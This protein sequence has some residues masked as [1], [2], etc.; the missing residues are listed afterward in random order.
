HALLRVRFPRTAEDTVIG[1][2]TQAAASLPPGLSLTLAPCLP[3]MMAEYMGESGAEDP[4]LPDACLR[5]GARAVVHDAGPPPLPTEAPSPPLTDALDGRGLVASATQTLVQVAQMLV[6]VCGL[7]RRC[8]PVNAWG[9]GLARVPGCL[10]QH[11][12]IDQGGQGRADPR[13]V[14]GRLGRKALQ[15]WCD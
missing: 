13:G 8:A 1:T 11:V 10:P 2:T 15:L 5:G 7:R 3:H 9:P 4:A 6:T 12:R 14:A